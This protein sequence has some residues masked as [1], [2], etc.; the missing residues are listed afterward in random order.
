MPTIEGFEHAHAVFTSASIRSVH[1]GDDV[2]LV[3]LRCRRGPA[4]HVDEC[5]RRAITAQFDGGAGCHRFIEHFL[6]AA[7]DR[8]VNGDRTSFD[9]LHRRTLATIHVDATSPKVVEPGFGGEDAVVGLPDDQAAPV[10]GTEPVEVH[11]REPVTGP[12]IHISVLRDSNH[13]ID[14]CDRSRRSNV[15]ALPRLVASF[16]PERDGTPSALWSKV[17]RSTS[18]SDMSTSWIS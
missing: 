7:M 8:A 17:R 9:S 11:L 6:S 15:R 10:L 13:L 2:H 4:P 18:A 3:H 12:P 5:A 16:Q 1:E 14:P